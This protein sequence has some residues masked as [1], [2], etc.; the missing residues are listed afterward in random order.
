MLLG[1][2]TI[3]CSKNQ[4]AIPNDDREPVSWLQPDTSKWPQVLLTNYAEF[5]G[6]SPLQG[7]S[8]FLVRNDNDVVVA[9]TARH[10]IG[11][12][13]GVEP[14]IPV[15]RLNDVLNGWVLFPR[16]DPEQYVRLRG[17]TLTP[18]SRA[19]SPW[20]EFDFLV[21]DLAEKPREGLEPLEIRQE[22]IQVGETVYLIGVPYDE[23]GGQNVYAG[24]VTARK[25]DHFR[26]DISPS[27]GLRGFSGA[28]IID[29]KGYA[30]GLMTLW[31]SASKQDG[32]YLEAGGQDIAVVIED[33]ACRTNRIVEPGE[34]A[35]E[36]A[37]KGE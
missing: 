7:A 18:Y 27:V 29:S 28:P 17:T 3:G 2:F 10:L 37:V 31:F 8:A 23:S 1:L 24:T 34:P 5:E 6:H 16:D 19:D 4:P 22:P 13:G 15:A 9:I 33:I 36:Q 21:L 35:D 26:F 14:E 32:K 25:G 12:Y 20:R 11:E 30:V